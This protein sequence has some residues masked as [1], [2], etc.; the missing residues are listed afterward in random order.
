MNVHGV[1]AQDMAVLT[2]GAEGWKE[3]R[4]V[5]L[6]ALVLVEAVEGKT[7]ASLLAR[8][9]TATFAVL[10]MDDVDGVRLFTRRGLAGAE[11]EAIARLVLVMPSP[12]AVSSL[13]RLLLLGVC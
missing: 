4:E 6:A 9:A 3:G 12:S 8:F 1:G 7:S 13:A 10:D 11:A 5:P 2:P